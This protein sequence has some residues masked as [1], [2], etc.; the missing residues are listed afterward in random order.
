MPQRPSQLGPSCPGTEETVLEVSGPC[1]HLRQCLCLTLMQ[2]QEAHQWAVWWGRRKWK[3]APLGP[4]S[5]ILAHG[6]RGWPGSC[7]LPAN[8]GSALFIHLLGL[9]AEGVWS[10]GWPG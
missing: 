8:P 1:P 7:F 9:G 10:Q 6:G 2:A 3:E 4:Q 5:G